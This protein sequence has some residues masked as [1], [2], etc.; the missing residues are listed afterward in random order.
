[1]HGLWDFQ[2][3]YKPFNQKIPIKKEDI[4]TDDGKLKNRQKSIKEYK[5][6]I[7]SKNKQI[8]N[9]NE[10]NKNLNELNKNLNERSL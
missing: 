5:L 6:L 4:F 3:R 10:R 8:K 7:K 9:L 2:R 1:M